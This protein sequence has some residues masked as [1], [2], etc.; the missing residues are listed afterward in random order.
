MRKL[1]GKGKGLAPEPEED[2]DEDDEDV[3]ETNLAE[4]SSLEHRANYQTAWQCGNKADWAAPCTAQDWDM[5]SRCSLLLRPKA[6]G[7]PNFFW[8]LHA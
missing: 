7:A 3:D 4:V 1:K 8:Q 5:T 2:E 6:P